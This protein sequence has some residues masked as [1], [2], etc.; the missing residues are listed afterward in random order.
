MHCISEEDGS[1]ERRTIKHRDSD[2]DIA[3][4]FFHFQSIEA[5][6]RQMKERDIRMTGMNDRTTSNKT[7]A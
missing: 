2:L 5:L 1:H 3:G 4:V 7:V 6:L